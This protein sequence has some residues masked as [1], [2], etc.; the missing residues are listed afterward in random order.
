MEKHSSSSNVLQQIKVK[1]TE[2]LVQIAFKKDLRSSAS[3]LFMNKTCCKIQKYLAIMTKGS[4]LLPE[5]KNR[6]GSE[7]AAS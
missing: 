5:K 4:H 2:K 6:M 7:K 1:L 3:E